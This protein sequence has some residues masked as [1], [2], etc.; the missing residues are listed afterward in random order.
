[1]SY[2]RTTLPHRRTAQAGFTLL[3]LAAV[4][5]VLFLLGCVLF[6]AAAMSGDGGKRAVCYNN[7]RQLG[8]ASVMYANENR[9]YLP[10]PN[11]DGGSTTAPAGWLYT[12][13][14]GSI[15]DPGPGGAYATN[16]VAAYATGLWFSYVRDPRVYLCPVDI[17]SKTYTATNSAQHRA[18]RLSSYIMNGAVCGYANIGTARSC[19]V[20]DAWSSSCYLVWGPDESIIGAF[21]FNDGSVFPNAS[22]GLIERLHTPT[23]GQ[24]LTVA[25]NVQFVTVQKS[26]TEATAS[27]KSLA[28]WSPFSGNG[29]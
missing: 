11:W 19:K 1:M 24:I 7:L 23:G 18:E 29:H 13:T 5:L 3:E 26:R 16:P 10:P 12:V 17:E 4:I 15:P 28:W 2:M 22:E 20:T 25:G 9:D 6:S 8:M 27:G 14:G 21:A